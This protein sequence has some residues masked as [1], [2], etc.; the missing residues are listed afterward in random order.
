MEGRIMNDVYTAFTAPCHTNQFKEVFN[1]DVGLYWA[2]TSP[3]EVKLN[4]RDG[5]HTE[6]W[7]LSRNLFV[8]AYMDWAIG[9]WI[10]SGDFGLCVRGETAML[11]LRPHDKALRAIILAPAP[12]V[13]TFIRD[14]CRITPVG[15]E[16]AATDR[17]VDAAI[18][19]LLA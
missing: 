9:A 10:G 8:N 5:D 4:L 13:E 15:Q 19:Y 16:Q 11:S 7:V 3:L 18:H 12:K 1:I 2:D 6:R 17:L 14:T